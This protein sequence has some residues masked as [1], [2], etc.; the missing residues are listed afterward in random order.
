MDVLGKF[1]VRGFWMRMSLS[2]IYLHRPITCTIN[3]TSESYCTL[4]IYMYT[5]S[6]I[7]LQHSHTQLDKPS[8]ELYSS[9]RATQLVEQKK[10]TLVFA[11]S[12]IC[13]DSRPNIPMHRQCDGGK[14]CLRIV[15]NVSRHRC[16]DRKKTPNSR[17]NVHG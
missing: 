12:C 16:K 3:N 8:P 14:I 6:Y 11:R 17:E 9:N 5:V 13:F 1:S 2:C 15:L 7:I 10:K 4:Y